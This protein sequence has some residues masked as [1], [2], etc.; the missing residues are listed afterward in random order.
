MPRI[1]ALN[2]EGNLV[3]RYG[4]PAEYIT[5]APSAH[6]FLRDLRKRYITDREIFLAYQKQF[7]REDRESARFF[8]ECANDCMKLIRAVTLALPHFGAPDKA[9]DCIRSLLWPVDLAPELDQVA[10]EL[11][12]A[13]G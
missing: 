5:P 13:F 12:L 2:D 3:D 10:R 4:W 6:D 1:K 11:L 7:G 8:K 9:Q